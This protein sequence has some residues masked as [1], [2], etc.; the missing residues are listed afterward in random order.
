MIEPNHDQNFIFLDFALNPAQ[1]TVPIYGQK[2]KKNIYGPKPFQRVQI[3]EDW[4][5]CRQWKSLKVKNIHTLVETGQSHKSA[6]K[7]C[8]QIYSS[9]KF[10]E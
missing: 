9:M 1:A 6:Y 7:K 8:H 2:C 10:V 4:L 3:C 5:L